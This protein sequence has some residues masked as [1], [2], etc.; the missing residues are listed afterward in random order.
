MLF[1]FEELQCRM[2]FYPKGKLMQPKRIISIFYVTAQVKH[3]FT[4]N[5]KSSKNSNIQG[6]VKV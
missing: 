3:V 5:H 4:K 2:K 1:S 6:E